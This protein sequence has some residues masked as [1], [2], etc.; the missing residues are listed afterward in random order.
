MF[1]LRT[2]LNELV[3]QWQNDPTVSWYQIYQVGEKLLAWKT[4]NRI[5][6]IW[7]QSP[8]M[9]TAT[10]DD[11]IGQGLKM[12]HLFS[13]IAGMDIEPLGLMQSK[14]T[15]IDACNYQLPD[16]L[17]MTILQYDTEEILNT[18]IPQF[19]KKMCIL[20][21]GPIFKMIPENELQ[22]KKYTSF[23]SI[24]DYLNFLLQYEM[25]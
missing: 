24:C 4:Q 15:I 11:A 3:N 16:F 20:V 10:M 6:G 5:A 2:I 12:I 19:P 22:H 13:R 14:E 7:K 23:N 25:E 8:K 17:G 18:I 9:I 1:K 21:G